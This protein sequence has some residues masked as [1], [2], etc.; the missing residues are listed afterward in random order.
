M[1]MLV[2]EKKLKNSVP[3]GTWIYYYEGQ[4]IVKIKESYEGG[5]LNGMRYTYYP[6]GKVKLEE[7]YKANLLAGPVKTYFDTG[8]LETVTEYRSNRKHGPYTAYYA[9][10]D[11]KGNR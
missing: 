9:K 1:G 10:R 4:K 6:S 11:R 3:E 5:K 7:S 2:S 8:A